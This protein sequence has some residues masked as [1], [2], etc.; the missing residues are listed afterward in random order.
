MVVRWDGKIGFLC[1][2][3]VFNFVLSSLGH[4]FFM[5][6]NLSVYVKKKYDPSLCLIDPSLRWTYIGLL[7]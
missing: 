6:K 1:W 5:N 7:F 3:P 2:P 4:A